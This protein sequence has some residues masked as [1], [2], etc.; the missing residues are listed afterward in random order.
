MAGKLQDLKAGMEK[1][2]G[3]AR[4]PGMVYGLFGLLVFLGIG[5]VAGGLLLIM[6][7]DG[8]SM[9]M[10]A[11]MMQRALFND[12]RIPGVLLFLV[13]GVLPLAVAYSLLKR[14]DW[15]LFDRLNPF[16]ELHSAWAWSLYIGFGQI[17]WITVQ[18]YVLNAVG[19]VHL[20]YIALG[21]AIQAVTLLPAVRGYCKRN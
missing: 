21:L 2:R 19:V 1:E 7:P 17:I 5:A 15:R 12:Y 20:F 6:N 18:T 10:P 11:T 14:P 13:F 4:R 16:K 3:V 9:G 8:K